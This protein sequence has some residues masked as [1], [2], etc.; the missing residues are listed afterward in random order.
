MLS[1]I[2]IADLEKAAQRFGKRE[3]V[4]YQKTLDILKT[5]QQQIPSGAEIALL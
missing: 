4:A 2:A 3:K 5:V 1:L